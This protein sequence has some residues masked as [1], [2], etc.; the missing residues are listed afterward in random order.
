MKPLETLIP[1][2]AQ[3]NMFPRAPKAPNERRFFFKFGTCRTFVRVRTYLFSIEKLVFVGKT[4]KKR[5]R[6]EITSISLQE[7]NYR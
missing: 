3:E 4:Y 6:N 2:S 7:E 1:P 5:L